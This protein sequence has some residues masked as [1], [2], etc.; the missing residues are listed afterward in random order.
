VSFEDAVLFDSMA[1][2]YRGLHES[3]FKIGDNVVVSGGGPIG[4]SAVQFARLAGA[5]HITVLE[6]VEAKRRLAANFGA[7]VVIDPVAEA[8]GV[9]EQILAL[10]DGIGADLVIEAAGAAKS[11]E[12]C[13]TLARA[14]GQVLHLGAGASAV[15]VLPWNLTLKELDIKSTLAFGAEEARKCLEFPSSKRFIT[16][17]MLSGVVSLSELVEKGFERLAA[18]KSLVKVAVAP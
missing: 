15:S 8:D 5:R 6:I 1:T 10:Y 12:T 18:D 9:Q 7:D 13:L 4:L 2:A 14:G 16:D 11:F 17:G 3:A